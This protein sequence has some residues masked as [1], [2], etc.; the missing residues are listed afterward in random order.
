M[1]SPLETLRSC[2]LPRQVLLCHM[3]SGLTFALAVLGQGSSK[4][5]SELHTYIA[6]EVTTKRPCSSWVSDPSA[7]RVHMLCTNL[8]V[9]VWGFGYAEVELASVL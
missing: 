2:G 4:L 9:Q 5:A 8:R 7:L 3:V 6:E 1:R